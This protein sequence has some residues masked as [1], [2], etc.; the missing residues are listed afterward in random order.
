MVPH[1][2]TEMGGG[3]GSGGE[4]GCRLRG[5]AGEGG[6]WADTLA[7]ATGSVG[8][9]GVNGNLMDAEVVAFIAWGQLDENRR[10]L[11]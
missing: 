3:C 2:I 6:A 10:R 4:R 11:P 8:N 1:N 7:D 5:E 9:S